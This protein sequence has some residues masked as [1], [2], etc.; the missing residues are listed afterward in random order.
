M[1]CGK[2]TVDDFL[3]QSLGFTPRST[4]VR[5]DLFAGVDP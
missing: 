5:G 2:Y 1:Y 3:Q 4:L